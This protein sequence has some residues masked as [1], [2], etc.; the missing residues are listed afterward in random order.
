M[1]ESIEGG[2]SASVALKLRVGGRVLG[3]AKVGHDRIVLREPSEIP[4]RDAELE[5]TIGGETTRQS[6]VLDVDG[7]TTVAEICYR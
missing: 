7:G 1:A 6:I 4:A 2:Y 3:V 5:I